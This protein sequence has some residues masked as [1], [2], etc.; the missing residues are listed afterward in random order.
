MWRESEATRPRGAPGGHGPPPPPPPLPPPPPPRKGSPARGAGRSPERGGARPPAAP[1]EPHREIHHARH[2]ATAS[3]P[4]RKDRREAKQSRTR[5]SSAP[6]E[7]NLR[8][9]HRYVRRHSACLSHALR[10]LAVDPHSAPA[11]PRAQAGMT[12]Q[13]VKDV[14]RPGCARRQAGR[15]CER[16]PQ[17]AFLLAPCQDPFRSGDT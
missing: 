5:C 1:Q 17:F 14:A 12:Y 3:R 15:S 16:L 8:C 4:G 10:R 13:C 11:R 7:G 2:Q 9:L 6:A